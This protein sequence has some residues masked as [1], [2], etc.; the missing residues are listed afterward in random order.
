MKDSEIDDLLRSTSDRI[1]LPASF[2][3]EVWRRIESAEREHSRA[4][5]GLREW[6]SWL[7]QEWPAAVGVAGAV[8]LGLALGALAPP[9][10]R[11][12]QASYVRS[13]SPFEPHEHR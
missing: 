2:R 13:I 3:H 8:A 10:A 11:D 1:S 12:A 9:D 4:P 5:G 7:F 6:V